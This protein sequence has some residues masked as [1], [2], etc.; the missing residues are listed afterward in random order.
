MLGLLVSLSNNEL[1]LSRFGSRIQ[2]AKNVVLA[3]DNVLGA[4]Q[5]GLATR[6]LS[7]KDP[8]AGL[9]VQGH[10]LAIFESFAMADSNDFTLL[11]FFLRRIGNDDPVPRGFLF[12][13][14]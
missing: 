10:Q 4:F 5:L 9:D 8:V 6:V 14:A 12:V 1:F 11:G 3:H 7:K 2:N 13:D